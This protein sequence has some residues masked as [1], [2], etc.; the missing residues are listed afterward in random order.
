[1]R[2]VKSIIYDLF[3]LICIILKQVATNLFIVVF[4]VCVLL[5]LRLA[6]LTKKIMLILFRVKQKLSK[7]IKTKKILKKMEAIK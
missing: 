3:S 4:F 1:M 7:I 2:Q 6:Y 5:F